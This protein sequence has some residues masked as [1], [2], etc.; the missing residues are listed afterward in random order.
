MPETQFVCSDLNG[1][2]EWHFNPEQGRYYR[3]NVKKN[4]VARI[5]GDSLPDPMILWENRCNEAGVKPSSD[6][7]KKLRPQKA[8]FDLWDHWEKQS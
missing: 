8:T 6:E 1:P 4:V 7:G 5:N 3:L 2:T